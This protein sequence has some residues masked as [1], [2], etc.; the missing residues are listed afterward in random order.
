[1][2]VVTWYNQAQ[3]IIMV[4]HPSKHTW[5]DSEDAFATI[6]AWVLASPRPVTV[7]YCFPPQYSVLMGVLKKAPT[8]FQ[9]YYEHIDRINQIYF[10][11]PSILIIHLGNIIKKMY[12]G[13]HKGKI[14]K[15]A[16]VENLASIAMLKKTPID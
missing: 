11:N 13:D 8:Y 15:F 14:E 12:S 7:I 9:W 4:T 16:F 10:V 5:Q 2:I 1:M 3:D 6:Q